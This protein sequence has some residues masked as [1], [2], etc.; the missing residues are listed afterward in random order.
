MTP[1]LVIL[2]LLSKGCCQEILCLY[3]YNMKIC[4]NWVWLW[5]INAGHL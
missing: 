5:C 3:E 2:D 1:P 4:E